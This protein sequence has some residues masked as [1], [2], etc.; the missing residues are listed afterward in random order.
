MSPGFARPHRTARRG[1]EGA[2]L[3]LTGLAAVSAFTSAAVALNLRRGTAPL[4]G[5]SAAAAIALAAFLPFA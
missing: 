4:A 3:L 2:A 1:T 5:V